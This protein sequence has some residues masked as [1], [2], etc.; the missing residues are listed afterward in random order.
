MT[1]ARGKST[2]YAPS[3]AAMAPEAPIV[4]IVDVGSMATWASAA[5]T[6]PVR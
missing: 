4:G 6:P 2:R 1:R 3:V 5:T